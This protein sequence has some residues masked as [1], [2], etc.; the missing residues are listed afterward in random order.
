MIGHDPFDAQPDAALGR[1]LREHLDAGDDGAFVARVRGM[2]ASE[3]DTSWDVLTRWARPGLAAAAS[4]AVGLG[5]WLALAGN[6]EP[7]ATLA[8]AIR[9]AGAPATVLAGAQAPS[10]ES[11]IGA[12]MVDR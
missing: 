4:I 9:P 11:V 5:L 12:L 10:S 8:D 6:P 7:S 1:L 2:L 3:R